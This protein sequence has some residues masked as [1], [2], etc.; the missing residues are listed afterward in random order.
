LRLLARDVVGEIREMLEQGEGADEA[1]ERALAAFDLLS[2]VA[3]EPRKAR[4]IK[5]GNSIRSEKQ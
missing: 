5:L 2:S 1:I 4:Q 3:R